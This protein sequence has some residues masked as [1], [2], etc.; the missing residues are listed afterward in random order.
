MDHSTMDHGDTDSC[1]ISMLL[2]YNTVGACFVSSRWKITSA[3]MFAGSCIGIVLLAMLVELLRRGVGEYDR[4]LIKQHVAKHAAAAARSETRSVPGDGTASRAG[5]EAVPIPSFRPNLWQQGVRALLHTAQFTVAYFIM[6]L[7]M[8]PSPLPCT[9]RGE[10]DG[11]VWTAMYYNV[12]VL[13][14]I[15]LGILVGS[16]IFQY[17]SVD[18]SY[19]LTRP[20]GIG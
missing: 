3:G 15:F 7:G 4:F 10:A 18:V 5:K 2:N 12:Y 20:R 9:E 16:Y 8:L 19:V 17:E 14:S 6:L 11:L 13:V 1:K